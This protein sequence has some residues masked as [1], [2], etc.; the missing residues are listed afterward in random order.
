MFY[1]RKTCRLCGTKSLQK[2]L[3]LGRQPLANA[4]LKKANIRR[5][6]QY[7]LCVMRCKNLACGFLQLKHVVDP[8]TLF[9]DYVYVSS[10]SAVFVRHFEEYARS[11]DKR[12]NLRGALTLDIGSND[13]VLINPLQE[14]GAK[15]LGVDPARDI[16]KLA[17]K[18]GF[19]TIVGYFDEK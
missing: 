15:A 4:F 19:E 9:G 12:L 13:G 17:N 5:E 3:D 16:A 1:E 8:D 10:T 11:M 2:V 18:E 6:K 14:L 7:P